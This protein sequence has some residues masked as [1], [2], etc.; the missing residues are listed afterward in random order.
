MCACKTFLRKLTTYQKR[1]I[2]VTNLSVLPSLNLLNLYSLKYHTVHLYHKVHFVCASS[3][4][5]CCTSILSDVV[6][7]F[8]DIFPK[9]LIIV[10]HD[11]PHVCNESKNFSCY[12][13]IIGIGANMVVSLDVI[14]LFSNQCHFTPVQESI[15]LK[16]NN[17][18][19]LGKIKQKY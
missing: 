10:Y 17:Y 4:C 16:Q 1:L 6:I 5:I 12:Y 19:V 14:E 9:G 18:Y 3:H 2:F 7:E 15:L 11:T 13:G 8:S